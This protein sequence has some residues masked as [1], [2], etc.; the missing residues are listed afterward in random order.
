MLLGLVLVVREGEVGVI[1]FWGE[2]FFERGR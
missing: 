2:G 1:S